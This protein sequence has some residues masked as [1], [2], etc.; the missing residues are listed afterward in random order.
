M[1]T[2][3]ITNYTHIPETLY[4]GNCSIFFEISTPQPNFNDQTHHR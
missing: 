2:T 4:P 1:L 3:S